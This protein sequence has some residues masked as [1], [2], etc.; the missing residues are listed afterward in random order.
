MRNN[1]IEEVCKKLGINH[2]S[3]EQKSEE[4]RYL[5]SGL[6]TASNFHKILPNKS[7]KY[8]SGRTTFMLELVSQIA[9][10][11]IPDEIHGKPLEW[12]ITYEPEARAKYSMYLGQEIK[13]V[14]F[15]VAENER[16]GA[17]PDGMTLDGLT[18]FE[19]K[20]PWNATHHT[21]FSL[22]ETKEEYFHQANYS[23]Y[24]TGAKKWHL[25]SYNPRCTVAGKDLIVME[26]SPNTELYT[27]YDIHISNFLKEMDEMLAE[28]YGIDFTHKYFNFKGKENG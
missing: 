13:D 8:G 3:L 7:G 5:R 9:D 12:G 26:F 20:C 6:I 11:S 25:I 16:L 24:L 4:W 19:I 14:P 1:K 10:R 21:A 17:S 28:T 22:G 27:Y 2:E 18:G 15:F 23:M